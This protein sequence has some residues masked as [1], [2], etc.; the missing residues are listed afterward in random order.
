[1][2]MNEETASGGA[3]SV[4]DIVGK[5]A[6]S[7]SLSAA[8]GGI[9]LL[10]AVQA[11]RRG[12]R[13]RAG[14][15][16]LAAAFWIGVAVFQRRSGGNESGGLGSVGDD[17]DQRSVADTS[18]DIGSI[19]SDTATDGPDAD[20]D[21]SDVVDT[22]SADLDESNTA[23]EFDGGDA[24]DID[25]RDVVDTNIG[26]DDVQRSEEPDDAEED[27]TLDVDED[28]EVEENADDGD[29]DDE[30]GSDDAEEERAAE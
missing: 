19:E 24:N 6:R 12:D 11:L 8:S 4:K 17:V 2:R 20:G 1:M 15:R 10:R 5:A 30:N 26:E 3:S 29:E 25:E 9:T 7:G 28:G 27:E 18:P 14:I 16:F 21:P 13:R 23:T 22:T